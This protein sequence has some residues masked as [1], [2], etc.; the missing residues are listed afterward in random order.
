MSSSR[1]RVPRAQRAGAD[2]TPTLPMRRIDTKESPARRRC[3][4]NHAAS[5]TDAHGERSDAPLTT[6]TTRLCLPRTTTSRR[7]VTTA[8]ASSRV[9]QYRPRHTETKQQVQNQR[10]GIREE[11]FRERETLRQSRLPACL[12][13]CLSAISRARTPKRPLP[14]SRLRAPLPL[15][16]SLSL[17]LSVGLSVS[18]LVVGL[19]LRGSNF[20]GAA[21]KIQ[22]MLKNKRFQYNLLLLFEIY[23]E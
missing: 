4:L 11:L 12:P 8:T 2:A 3:A 21:E 15:S 10:M 1:A 6:R 18:L 13:P 16:L 20:L 14:S 9:D 7:R 5:V 22:Y 23:E 19:P 17:S